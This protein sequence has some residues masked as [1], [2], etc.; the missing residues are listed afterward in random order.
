MTRKNETTTIEQNGVDIHLLVEKMEEQREKIDSLT[1]LC[2]NQSQ[3]IYQLMKVCQTQS[4]NIDQ[5]NEACHNLEQQNEENQKE[6]HGN[7][8][9]LQE[10]LDKHEQ[11]MGEMDSKLNV[12][13]KYINDLD[14]F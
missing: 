10:S 14:V 11:K 5:L 8:I 9:I 4:Q 12:V 1:A 3:M 13:V 2:K 6:I 7:N